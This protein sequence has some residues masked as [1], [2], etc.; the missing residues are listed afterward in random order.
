[1]EWF[2][3]E[4]N[5]FDMFFK[6]LFADWTSY[7]LVCS[8]FLLWRHLPSKE[9]KHKVIWYTYDVFFVIS[10]FI[11]FN[12]YR[13]CRIKKKII[14]STFCDGTRFNSEITFIFL[15]GQ[16]RK[17][18]EKQRIS[19]PSQESFREKMKIDYELENHRLLCLIN[20]K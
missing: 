19:I 5:I 6:P 13:G 10:C 8:T 12:R 18:N 20:V 9:S 3:F 4:R 1:M 2:R 16:T 14:Y 17:W 11:I 15:T 7:I